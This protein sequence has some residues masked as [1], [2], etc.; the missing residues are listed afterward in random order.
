VT[1]AP[2]RQAETAA[3]LRATGRLERADKLERQLVA[4]GRCKH[5][6]RKLSD[7][8]SIERGVGSDCWAKGR[9]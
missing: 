1:F 9:R 6:G 7:P 5:C 2:G 8:V 3:R 4:L